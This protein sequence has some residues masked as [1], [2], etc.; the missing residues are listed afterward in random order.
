MKLFEEPLV[1]QNKINV[2]YEQIYPTDNFRILRMK[3]TPTHRCFLHTL[4]VTKDTT[5]TILV[6]R[7]FYI[8]SD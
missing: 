2:F 6:R 3:K 1:R 7:Y 4:V 8:M 5:K